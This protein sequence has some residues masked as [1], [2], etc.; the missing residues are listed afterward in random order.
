MMKSMSAM[1]PDHRQRGFSI[2]SAI[3][4]LVVLSALGAFML[5]FSNVQQMTS[6]QD[7]QGSRAYQAARAGIEWGAYQILQNSGSCAGSATVPLGGNLASFTL[8]VS[9][10]N[11]STTEAGSPVNICQLTATATTGTVGSTTYIE[12][13]VQATIAH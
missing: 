9:Y 13:Q 12:R 3:F 8:V 1:R 11:S 10:S 6:A 2:V 4:L 5:T 7:V